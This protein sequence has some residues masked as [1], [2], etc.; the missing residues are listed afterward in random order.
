MRYYNIR[1]NRY[2]SCLVVKRIHLYIVTEED[3]FFLVFNLRE[4][5]ENLVGTRHTIRVMRTFFVLLIFYKI[6]CSLYFYSD[7]LTDLLSF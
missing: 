4:Y 5:R 7:V 2:N 1:Y 6:L 3:I